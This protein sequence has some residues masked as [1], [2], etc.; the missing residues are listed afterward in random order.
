MHK[1]EAS[2]PP[3]RV[4][5]NASGAAAVARFSGGRSGVKHGWFSGMLST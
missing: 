2:Q 1:A 5:E 4:K 3:R